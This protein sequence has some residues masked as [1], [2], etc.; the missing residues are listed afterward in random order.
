[1]NDCL[2]DYIL[3]EMPLRYSIIRKHMW[4]QKAL[5]DRRKAKTFL[6]TLAELQAVRFKFM[7]VVSE[8]LHFR[9]NNPQLQLTE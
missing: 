5:K 4:I 3:S 8:V 6:I 2:D 9:N 7:C 1:M